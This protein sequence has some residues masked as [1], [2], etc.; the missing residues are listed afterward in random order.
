M[1]QNWISWR[2]F[3]NHQT[4]HFIF[5]LL[6]LFISIKI[7]YP[8]FLLTANSN[9]A[10]IV[11]ELDFCATPT[12][13]FLLVKSYKL[14]NVQC[15]HSPW[16]AKQASVPT[17]GGGLYTVSWTGLRSGR[18]GDQHVMMVQT[19]P[20]FSRLFSSHTKA[21]LLINCNN[22]PYVGG[23]IKSLENM[24]GIKCV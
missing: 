8:P 10:E 13:A 19:F 5:F 3:T 21:L 16:E 7:R 15:T 17:Q 18:S 1:R 14:T 4:V 12:W 6:N 11:R 20:I 2:L 23:T 9:M 24:V 22:L